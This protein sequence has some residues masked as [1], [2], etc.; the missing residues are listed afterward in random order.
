MPNLTFDALETVPEGLKD[1]AKKDDASGK[2]VVDVVPGVKLAEFRDNNIAIS[3]QRDDL[4]AVVSKLKPHVGEDLDAFIANLGEMSQTVQQLKDGKLK[5]TGDIEAEV[6][7]RV[8]TMK[9]GYDNQ[10]RELGTR[11]AQAEQTAAVAD[12]KFKR[13]I[14]D[15]AVTQAVVNPDSGAL[16][17]AL[18]DILTRAY[19]VFQV[20]DDG[21][22]TAKD[23]EAIIYGADGVTP[24]TPNEWMGKLREQ[25]PHFFKGS[26]GGGASGGTNQP[27]SF[28]GHS[29]EDLAKMTPMQKLTL[30]HQQK[31]A[32]AAASR[33]KK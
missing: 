24:M 10:I 11:A 13:S 23:G 28:A 19:R 9:T 25:A 15:R 31:A 4:A 5:A 14:V 16:P 18:D 27:G 17:S 3:K 6:L 2:F 29:A 26:N 21:K 30:V 22:L 20:S 33:A 1:Y 8:E 7:R 12:Q 32:E